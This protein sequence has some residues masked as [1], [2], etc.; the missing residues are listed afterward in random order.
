MDDSKKGFLVGIATTIVSILVAIALAGVIPPKLDRMCYF[1]FG[2]ACGF[3]VMLAFIGAVIG[4]HVQYLRAA[5]GK[6]PVR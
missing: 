3:G 4:P 1:F 5:L 2:F 6:K